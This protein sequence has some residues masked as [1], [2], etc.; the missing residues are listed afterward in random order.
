M[1]FRGKKSKN[2]HTES[3]VSASNIEKVP[4]VEVVPDFGN[5]LQPSGGDSDQP[6]KSITMSVIA[7]EVA[8]SSVGESTPEV[9][10][11]P[12]IIEEVVI[13]ANNS[14]L[15]SRSAQEVAES[16]VVEPGEPDNR[17]TTTSEE[18]VGVPANSGLISQSAEE[19]VESEVVE[20]GEPDNR[21][22]TTTEELVGVPVNSDLISQSAEPGNPAEL[23]YAELTM[24]PT[25]EPVDAAPPQ[26]SGE[27]DEA[28]KIGATESTMA[29]EPTTPS[30]PQTDVG[31]YIR[32]FFVC[33]VGRK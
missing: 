25:E 10:E 9:I 22:T 13:P 24:A 21:V 14:D 2:K 26:D 1:S 29:T 19:V 7:Q 30:E 31:S 5:T 32:S 15:I 28:M 6:V 16:Q 8:E 17:V 33:C 11:L 20:P 18:P 27:K 3:I 4:D 23:L 12:E